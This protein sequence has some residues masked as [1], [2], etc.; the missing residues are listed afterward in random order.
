MNMIQEHIVRSEEVQ[1]ILSSPPSMLL[2]IGSM[3][4]ALIL[5]VILCGCFVFKY[6]DNITC[7]VTITADY[8][9][10]V[11]VANAG[12]RLKELYVPDGGE[13]KKGDIIGVIE[14]TARTKDVL[15]LDS[16]LNNVRIVEGQPLVLFQEPLI[17][18]NIQNSY[19]NLIK[20]VS[21]YNNFITNNLYNQR[22]KAEEALQEPNAD[23]MAAV[24]QQAYLTKKM[25]ALTSSNYQ[26]EKNLHELGLTSTA[27]MEAIEQGV[28]SSNMQVEQMNAT[29]ANTRIQIAQIRNN[30]A[31]LKMQKEQERKQLETA[32]T[33]ALE[34]IHNNISEWKQTFV[35][36]SPTDG[37]VSYNN[38]WQVNQ[39][40]KIGDNTFSVIGHKANNIIGKAKVPIMG[41]GKVQ[42]GQRVNIKLHGFPYLEYGFL[43]AKVV[44]LSK[45]PDE[46]FYTATLQ[47]PQEMK[48][49]YGKHIKYAGDM[50]GEAEIVTENLTVAERMVA[51]LRYLW[52]RNL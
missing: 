26:R 23:Y 48:T 28:L 29:I 6:P 1:D 34:T 51:P 25:G 15:R 47:L 46:N 39:N 40:I 41:A 50:I 38:L 18:G 27:D 24:Q 36:R 49:S 14:N 5:A 20:S 52:S 30:I 35:L 9:P 21:D 45:M 2:R 37:I 16:I 19:N 12:G 11:I 22:I 43:K 10:A 44:A 13:V 7:E 8:P 32:L 3:T 17:L 42:P 31:E 4:I 33:A